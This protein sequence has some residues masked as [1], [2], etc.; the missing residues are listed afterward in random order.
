MMPAVDPHKFV[1][2]RAPNSRC[3]RWMAY[4]PRRSTDRAITSVH[5]VRAGMF[6][7]ADC[8][9]EALSVR[10][11]LKG[12]FLYD[13][14]VVQTAR[15]NQCSQTPRADEFSI[16]V[17]LLLDRPFFRLLKK[18]LATLGSGEIESSQMVCH[19]D[20]WCWSASGSAR[21]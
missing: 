5:Y 17:D 7:K 1:L 18:D 14:F 20:V 8:G 10:V 4:T 21:R 12:L 16:L 3:G 19:H 11:S 6:V 9:C 15:V 13:L 2:R